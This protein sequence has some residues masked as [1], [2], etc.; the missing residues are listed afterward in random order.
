[1]LYLDMSTR[2]LIVQIYSDLHLE[3]TKSIQQIVP[4]APYLFLAEDISRFSHPS[5]RATRLL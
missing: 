2:K 4:I 1:M 3:L 5:F